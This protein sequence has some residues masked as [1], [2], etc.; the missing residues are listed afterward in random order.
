MLSIPYIRKNLEEV[1]AGLERKNVVV[2]LERL[3]KLD[4]KRRQLK[5]ETD[6]LRSKQNK[7]SKEIGAAPAEKKQAK[8]KEMKSVS[9]D[10][11]SGLAE[12]EKTENK[13]KEMLITIPN[14]AHKTVPKGKKDTDSVVIRTEGKK[15]V[16]G[17]KPKDHVELG[18]TLDLMDV[19]RAAKVSGS[20]F[21]YLKNE[22]ALLEYALVQYAFN[23]LKSKGF[24]PV[25]PPVLVKGMAMYGTG[26]LP[27]DESQIYKTEHDD[28]YLVGTSE[29]SIAGYHADEILNEDELPKRYAGFSTCFRRE[30]GT[31]GKDMGGM[32]RV[33]QFDK[34]EMFSFAKPD[35]SYQEHDFILSIEE[36]IMKDMGLHYN[37][38][39]ICGCDLGASAAKKYD[40]DVYLPGQDAF[41]ELTSTSNTTDYQARRLNI[42]MRTEK[43]NVNVHT[44]NGT[45]IAL[46][47]MLIALMENGQQKDGSI[48]IPGV[49]HKYAGFEKIGPKSS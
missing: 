13:V 41:R 42:R 14:P 6:K 43:E 17:F 15:P 26:F 45:A 20:R 40:L 49:L 39:N 30:A 7:A 37:V 3:L 28:L 22:L 2:N 46:G 4:D 21:V 29:V 9:D 12:L 24:T 38:V 25:V 31:Y 48:K 33:H 11:K 44:V 35:E 23:K 19:E 34:V 47:R 1:K 5:T 18:K 8:I 36:E 27:A 32:F 10:L 16:F